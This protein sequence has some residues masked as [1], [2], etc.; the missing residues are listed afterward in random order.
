MIDYNRYA[1]WVDVKPH[2]SKYEGDLGMPHQMVFGVGRGAE[3]I[4]GTNARVVVGLIVCWTLL[5]PQQILNGFLTVKNIKPEKCAQ[6]NPPSLSSIV[7]WTLLWPEQILNDFLTVQN[8][9]C[10]IMHRS[11]LHHRRPHSSFVVCSYNRRSNK[12]WQA[13][14]QKSSSPNPNSVSY[15]SAAP[16]QNACIPQ[17]MCTHGKYAAK[18]VDLATY[19]PNVVWLNKRKCTS[20]LAAN[21]TG[22]F[23][24]QISNQ[25]MSQQRK[26]WK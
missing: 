10:K 13:F 16:P 9:S 24:H 15:F 18:N 20:E 5:C 11:I 19:D 7:C 17:K 8:I 25:A 4:F 22:M 23:N 6:F 26:C 12:A 21:E 14:K 1:H 3:F 2:C